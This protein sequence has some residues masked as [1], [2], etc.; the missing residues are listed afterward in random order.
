M[1]TERLTADVAFCDR[2]ILQ[3]TLDMHQSQESLQRDNTRKAL[4]ALRECKKHF[5]RVVHV[6]GILQYW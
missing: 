3:N 2:V 4:L 6:Q 1:D 5:S